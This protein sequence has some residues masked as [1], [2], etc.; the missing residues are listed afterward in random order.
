MNRMKLIRQTTQ[1]E[2]GL[3][4]ISMVASFY[5]FVQPISYY[6]DR[7][8][9]GRDGT[10]LKDIYIILQTIKSKSQAM[11]ITDF[12]KYEFEE[13]P[14]IVHLQS[15]HFVVIKKASGDKL[16]M[17]DPAKGKSKISVVDL[18][19]MSSGYCLLVD[20]NYD[21]VKIKNKSTEFRHIIPAIKEITPLIVGVLILSFSVYIISILIPLLLKNII[22]SIVGSIS[23]NFSQI[24][25]RA[26][27]IA[28][29]FYLISSLR[30]KAMVKLQ[31]MLYEKISL[32][33]ISHL[34][35][36]KY[37]FYDNRSKGDVLYRL[38]FLD[39]IQ[40]AIS[41]V[42]IQSLVSF[43]GVF[44]VLSYLSIKYLFILPFLLIILIAFSGTF[45]L[46]NRIILKLRQ[47]EMQSKEKVESS[48]TEIVNNMYQIKCL[49]LSDYFYNSYKRLFDDFLN[50]FASS[51]KNSKRLNLILNVIF[52]FA[53]L[54]ILIF[55]IR[56]S[57]Y[58]SVGELFAL[59][60]LFTTVFS[61][62]V[63]LVSNISSIMLLK[64]SI[65]YLNDLLDEKQIEPN[66]SDIMI[67]EFKTLE[68]KNV[69]FCYSDNS[70]NIL[71]NINMNIKRGE[72]IAIV[73]ASGT[74][75]TTLVKL[76]AGLYS[77]TDGQII[78]NRNNIATISKDT[79]LQTLSIVTQVPVLFNKTIRNNIILDDSSISDEEVI[80]ALSYSNLWEEVK[81]MPLGLD[82]IISGQGGNLSGGQIQRLSLARALVR[83]P[84][85]LVMDE[86]TSSLDSINEKI[87]Y[88]NLK[89]ACITQIVISHRLSTIMNADYI[90]VLDKGNII[91]HG[92]HNDLIK[93]K[94]IYNQ[95]FNEQISEFK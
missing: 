1:S 33:T 2:C 86:A 93:Q 58:F 43:T 49:H 53:P 51:E 5:G 89:E 7:F 81:N 26:L 25:M 27:S 90:Y 17:W 59:Y 65:F 69:N 74:G 82:T 19:K 91:E 70:P 56:S 45:L 80:R 31:T 14:Y 16:F 83:H 40:D 72:C 23:V 20:K 61:Q 75:K 41:G 24:M 6:R 64:A 30:N 50:T 46:L 35:K 9:V 52:T 84:Q 60:S 4:C 13:K 88:N 77:P 38:S 42:F 85:L 44:A 37:S 12:T 32:K 29:A 10:S 8:N 28:I 78:M 66:S 67:N 71:T 57:N 87:I 95:M 63:V 3:C 11:Q 62:C 76:I 15:S 68:I 73:G 54:F 47:R 55:L 21:F 34:F 18:Q 22:N 79:Y 92:T 94:G 39:Q 36:I 48:I